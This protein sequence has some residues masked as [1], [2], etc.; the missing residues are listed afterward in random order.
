MPWNG[1]HSHA[2]FGRGQEIK[3]EIL[4]QGTICRER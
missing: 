3:D 2:S 1:L 4:N